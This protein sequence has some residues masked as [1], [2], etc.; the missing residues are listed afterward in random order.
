MVNASSAQVLSD[1]SAEM[2]T[3]TD[4]PP[5]VSIL[6]S[7]DEEKAKHIR[8]DSAVGLGSPAEEY[9]GPSNPGP[10]LSWA[11]ST[12]P[13]SGDPKEQH[14]R[15]PWQFEHAYEKP[16]GSD[17]QSPNMI[18]HFVDFV[19]V[20]DDRMTRLE[21]GTSKRLPQYDNSSVHPT[22]IQPAVTQDVSETK[23]A[24]LSRRLTETDTKATEIL[25]EL[26]PANESAEKHI[27]RVGC[28]NLA[29]SSVVNSE[30]TAAGDPDPRHIEMIFISIKSRAIS[31][32]LEAQTGFKFDSDGLI[33]VTRPFKV[34]IQN[35]VAMKEQLAKLETKYG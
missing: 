26:C 5:S 3:S 14:H 19:R 6:P 1:A 11:K 32:F 22:S 30:S 21:N 2:S 29:S 34:L 25:R 18:K 20:L 12:T 9:D 10:S 16:K 8:I 27:L 24:P 13:R 7:H 23:F 17:E 4:N 28:H 33:H 15:S 35:A 31:K